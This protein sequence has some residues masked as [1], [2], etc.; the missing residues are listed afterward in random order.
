MYWAKDVED[1]ATWQEDKKRTEEG[2]ASAVA[3]PKESSWKKEEEETSHVIL[4]YIMLHFQSCLVTLLC[5][6]PLI[7]PMCIYGPAIL[8]LKAAYF[9]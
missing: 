9:V 7:T 4:D 8:L 2:V 3:T 5:P 1:G 6:I